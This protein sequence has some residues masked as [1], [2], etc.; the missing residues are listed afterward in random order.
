MLK[1]APTLALRHLTS[2]GVFAALTLT[3]CG[4]GDSGSLNDVIGTV[5]SSSSVSSAASSISSSSANTGDT[6]VWE[7]G[8]F[9]N[10]EDYW[11]LCENPRQGIAPYNGQAYPDMAGSYIDENV[12][13]R[14]FS[15]EYYLW[16]DEIDDRNP[17]LFDTPTYFDLLVT[18]ER[19]PSGALKDQFHWSE[20]TDTYRARQDSGIAVDYGMEWVILSSV[21][22]REVVVVYTEPSSSAGLAGVSRGASIVSI[23]GIDLINDD[24][25]EGINLLNMA[26]IPTVANQ[27]HTFTFQ[28]LG[29]TETRDVVLTATE[30][31]IA[32]VNKTNIINT[33]TGDVGYML[34]NSHIATAETEL[35]NAIESFANTGVSD[36][37]LDLRY[38]GGGF[39]DIASELGYMVG[40]TNVADKDF[41][42]LR[43]NDKHPETDPFSGESLAP[44]KFHSTTQNFSEPEGQP[45]PTLNLNRVYVLTGSGTCSASEAVINGLAGADVEVIQIGNATC[46]KPYGAY[47]I[48]NCGKSYFTT[49]FSGTNAKGFGDYAAGFFPGAADSADASELPGCMVN[50]D[51]THALGDSNEARLAAALYYRDHGSCP[52]DTAAKTSV[53]AKTHLNTPNDGIMF[54]PPGMGDAIL[55]TEP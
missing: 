4:G 6:F 29:S 9:P 26:L 41:Y 28:E 33:A 34:F 3:A 48:D 47:V 20:N 37:V 2:W 23:D 49:Q 40:G 22:P 17:I 31:A 16:Y 13:L 19:T 30:A 32:S 38:N 42:F 55:R 12:F 52:A 54:H 36:L 15:N 14:S 45:L 50:D 53:S 46:G 18:Q 7:E 39:L 44:I 35:I 24:S 25:A 11:S 51:Y 21:P 5:S 1:S 27:S 8:V 10:L 43:F